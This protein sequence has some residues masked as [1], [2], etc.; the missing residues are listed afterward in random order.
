VSTV[1]RA[2]ESWEGD[3]VGVLGLGRSGRGAVALLRRHGARVVAFDDRTD[4]PSDVVADLAEWD[5]EIRTGRDDVSGAVSAFDALVVSPGVPGDHPLVRAAES[6]GRPVIGELELAAR[7]ARGRILAVTGTNGKSTTVSL[8]QAMLERAGRES[9]LVGNIGTA[10]SDHVERVGEGGWLVIECSSFQLERIDVFAPAAAA[11]LNLAPDHLDRYDSFE[12]YG[13]AK[14]NI[15]SRAGRYVF[16]QDDARLAGW[17]ATAD[18]TAFPFAA[19]YSTDATAWV[20]DATIRRRYAGRVEEILP[21]DAI[22][23]VGRHNVSNV[24]AAVA[25]VD[26][27]GIDAK[28]IA[29]AVRDF[30]GLP[31]RAVTVASKDGL[32][33]IDDSKATNVHAAA[34][35]LAGLNGPV[36]ALFGGRGKGEDYS[37]LAGFGDRMRAAVCFGEEGPAIARALDGAVPCETVTGMLDAAA[38]AAAIARDGDVVLLSPACASFDE[39]RGFAAR[40]EVFQRWVTDHRG[41]VR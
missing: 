9:V 14:R 18:A 30:E 13:E 2:H 16:P 32:T 10:V 7:R 4:L 36:V 29:V 23:L 35:T 1:L 12:A 8:V 5:V 38:R 40:G 28:D 21:V 24:L 31:H 25:L 19:A 22:P 27:C 39:F 37:A 6:V 17:A 26:V 34:A 3:A 41:S 11:I 33:W 15:L 20:E